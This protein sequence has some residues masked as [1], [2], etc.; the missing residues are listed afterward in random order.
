MGEQS[1]EEPTVNVVPTENVP[2]ENL[3]AENVVKEPKLQLDQEF[4]LIE[5]AYYY[6]ND[7]YAKAIGFSVRMSSNKKSKVTGEIIWK[8]FLCSKERKTDETYENTRRQHS[9]T[10]E[11]R[12]CGIK[13]MS[14]KARLNIV[15]NK[16]KKNWCVSGFE[17]A[18]THALTTPKKVYL[19]TSRTPYVSELW[20]GWLRCLTDN[21]EVMGSNL[22]TYVGCVSY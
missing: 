6:Y 17:E 22:T 13:H 21:F 18:H 5:E 4:E 20:L 14:C 1:S 16:E 12:N 19:L 11:E 2:D 8:Q 3:I 10:M 9:S 7:I 15:F